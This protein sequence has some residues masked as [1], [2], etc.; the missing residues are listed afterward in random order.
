MK[1][2]PEQNLELSDRQPNVTLIVRLRRDKELKI[3]R[4]LQLKTCHGPLISSKSAMGPA[5]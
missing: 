3:E 5:E 4:D 2:R 1:K